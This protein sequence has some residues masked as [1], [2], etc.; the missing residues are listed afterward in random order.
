MKCADCARKY[1]PLCLSSASSE[2]V[3]KV[4]RPT[5]I[6]WKCEDCLPETPSTAVRVG[7]ECDSVKE[8]VLGAIAE[9]RKDTNDR[10]DRSHQKLD[11]RQDDIIIGVV[12]D[13]GTLKKNIL[14][15]E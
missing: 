2:A 5:R 13:V 8:A 14:K 1:Q 15:L 3:T 12:K 4:S 10:L 6:N 11:T 9:F 7:G